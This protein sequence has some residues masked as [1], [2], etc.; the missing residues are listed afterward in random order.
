MHDIG[1]AEAVKR[2]GNMHGHDVIGAE[3]MKSV[4]DSLKFSTAYTKRAVRLVRWHMVDLA[5]D[6]SE[7]KL[8]RFVAKNMDIVDDLCALMRADA[9]ASCGR[10]D[11]EN[12]IALVAKEL[13]EDGTPLCIKDLKVS[14][15]DLVRLGIEEKDRGKVLNALWEDTVMNP[16]LN[17]R[18]KALDYIERMNKKLKEGKE[19]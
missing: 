3:M 9:I 1:K 17:D 14:G 13:K 5:G 11:K 2:Y 6:M 4:C 7:N 10:D 8:R 12:R 15:D 18:N 19:K 16:A